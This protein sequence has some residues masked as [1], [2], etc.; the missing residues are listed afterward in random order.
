MAPTPPANLAA[1]PNL[2]VVASVAAVDTNLSPAVS[3]ENAA[4]VAAA[5]SLP[6]ETVEKPLVVGAAAVS[7]DAR[8]RL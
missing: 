8:D 7:A 6:V 1:A 3:P 5:A 4:N 2:A